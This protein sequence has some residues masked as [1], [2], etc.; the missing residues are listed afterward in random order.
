MDWAQE[1]EGL[2]HSHGMGKDGTLGK[3]SEVLEYQI[4]EAGEAE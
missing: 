3:R 4:R 2:A 1:W